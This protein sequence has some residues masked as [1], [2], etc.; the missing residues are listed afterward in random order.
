MYSSWAGVDGVLPM[1]EPASHA[2][3]ASQ[4]T[5]HASHGCEQIVITRVD[6]WWTHPQ[7]KSLHRLGSRLDRPIRWYLYLLSL[8]CLETRDISGGHIVPARLAT[9]VDHLPTS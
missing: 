1:C 3:H 9:F 8:G 5:S 7:P 4:G 6:D 2:S